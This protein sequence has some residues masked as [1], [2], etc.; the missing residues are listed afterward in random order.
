MLFSRKAKAPERLRVDPVA[1]DGVGLC[2]HLAPRL[3]TVDDWGYPVLPNGVLTPAQ[4]NS[5][6]LAVKGCPKRALFLDV[7]RY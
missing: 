6:K 1:C 3:I 7:D 5:A 2:A 4:R